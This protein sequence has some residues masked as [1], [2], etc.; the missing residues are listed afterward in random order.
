VTTQAGDLPFML[1]WRIKEGVLQA[2]CDCGEQ[3]EATEPV[4]VLDWLEQHPH[5]SLTAR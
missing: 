2:R 5:R 1:V 3:F 4:A